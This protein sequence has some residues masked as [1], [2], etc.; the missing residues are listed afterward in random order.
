[1]L[2]KINNHG[3]SVIH[4]TVFIFALLMGVFGIYAFYNNFSLNSVLSWNTNNTVAQ[5]PTGVN[6]TAPQNSIQYVFVKNGDSKYNGRILI[7]LKS[8]NKQMQGL[9]ARINIDGVQIE[10]YCSFTKCPIYKTEIPPK[11]NTGRDLSKSIY[12]TYSVAVNSSTRVV[13]ICQN[14]NASECKGLDMTDV[15]VPFGWK[16][17]PD[18]LSIVRE[19]EQAVVDVNLV[20]TVNNQQTFD[21]VIKGVGEGAN[22]IV[23]TLR[24]RG[25]K[26]IDGKNYTSA[27]TTVLKP[28]VQVGDGFF[29]FSVVAL[30]QTLTF[31]ADSM[32]RN[33]DAVPGK[34]PSGWKLNSNKDG[35]DRDIKISDLAVVDVTFKGN[36]GKE[37]VYEVKVTG[38]RNS[39]GV[40]DI[41]NIIS[42]SGV[43]RLDGRNYNSARV[44]V[45]SPK[46]NYGNGFLTFEVRAVSDTLTFF[47]NAPNAINRS[48]QAEPGK[49]PAGWKINGKRDGLDRIRR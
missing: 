24:L 23:K 39:Q 21:V 45:L 28:Q 8:W 36:V 5:L 34:I 43:I 44:T 31:Y 17:G 9:A 30:P 29:R 14:K 35:I 7:Q 16:P 41:I 42:T 40:K 13:S 46:I 27:K 3:F 20:R 12:V 6:K 19:S 1:M 18:G 4:I 11:G 48:V 33:V 32:D 15:G 2:K 47:V 37:E 49:I 10:E 38:D 25:L 26:R 22:S